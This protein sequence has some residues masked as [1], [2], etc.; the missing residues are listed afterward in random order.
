MKRSESRAPA[1]S[2]CRV[3]VGQFM[4]GRNVVRS[5]IIATNTFCVSELVKT[6]PAGS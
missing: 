2:N 4:V 5:K 1:N 6:D 3:I